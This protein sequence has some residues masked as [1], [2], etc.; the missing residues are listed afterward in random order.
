MKEYLLPYRYV[1]ADGV[2]VSPPG[3]VIV[4]RAPGTAAFPFGQLIPL[5]TS[6]AA[7]AGSRAAGTLARAGGS[8]SPPRPPRRAP[9]QV[10]SGRPA[11][12][13]Q[14]QQAQQQLSIHD[15]S[16]AWLCNLPDPVAALEYLQRVA[17]LARGLVG[18]LVSQPGECFATPLPCGFSL[19]LVLLSSWGCPHYV[20]L[21]GI[22]VRDAVRGPLRIRPEQVVAG[23][24]RPSVMCTSCVL[25][26][27]PKACSAQLLLPGLSAGQ[28]APMGASQG[29]LPALPLLPA[30]AAP[31]SVA[32]M[33]GMSGDARTP[34]K[35]VDGNN[36]WGLSRKGGWDTGTALSSY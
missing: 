7:Q 11:P 29:C 3:G 33:P 5:H 21:S 2:E 26:L 9:L 35:L 15:E 19:R 13:Q 18:G 27:A 25:N 16:V 28:A 20:G 34:D 24:L 4:R 31:S 10:A 1:A 14:A 23:G 12:G 30:T 36:R 6:W 22:E 17:L 32:T 8:S